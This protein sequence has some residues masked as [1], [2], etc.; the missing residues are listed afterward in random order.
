MPL[1]MSDK[2]YFR[3]KKT[4]RNLM[5]GLIHHE[6][7]EG[8]NACSHSSRVLKYM[9]QILIKLKEIINTH[10]QFQEISMTNRTSGWKFNKEIEY[11][12]SIIQLDI[13]KF[14]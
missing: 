12:S 1:L 11:I 4:T 14:I 7:I 10:L 3:M 9:K 2:E 6:N 13:T 8:L 5:K